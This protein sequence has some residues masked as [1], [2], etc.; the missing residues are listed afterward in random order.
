M[1]KPI[2]IIATILAVTLGFLIVAPYILRSRPDTVSTQSYRVARE[3]QRDKR[4]TVELLNF[5]EK[6]T[7]TKNGGALYFSKGPV[8]IYGKKSYY[9]IHES[10]EIRAIQKNVSD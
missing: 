10:G 2:I 5:W 3:F 8:R 4:E 7:E 6:N 9:M 1:K